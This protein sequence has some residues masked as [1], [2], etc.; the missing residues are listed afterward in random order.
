MVSQWVRER[1]AHLAP[2]SWNRELATIRSGVS[3]W[4]RQGWIDEDPTIWLEFRR[5]RPDRTRADPPTGGIRWSRGDVA[6]ARRLWRLPYETAARQRPPFG[7]DQLKGKTALLNVV[8]SLGTPV[9]HTQ[10][11][12]WDTEAH[13]LLDVMVL[14]ISQDL[15]F[16]QHRWKT[17]EGVT[18]PPCR[19]IGTTSSRPTMVFWSRS[20][21]SCSAP[22]S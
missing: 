13:S 4:R 6:H 3:W 7:S 22:S 15:P 5:D 9:C 12:R 10:T 20:Y 19:P 8:I 14:T 17:A 11:K 2:A 21:K 1:R 16:A 18:P